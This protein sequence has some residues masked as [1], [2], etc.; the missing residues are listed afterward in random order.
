M[1][2]TKS[3]ARVTP[4]PINVFYVWY[5]ELC[6]RMNCTPAPAVKPA[7]PK[8][9]TILEFVADRLRVEEWNPIVNALRHD[10]SLHVISIRGRI[11]NCQFLVDI[12]TEEKA[13]HMKRRFGSL[14]TAYVL[15]QL[16]KSL[17]C[18]LR[19]TQ[20]LTCLE[21]DGLPM[22]SQYIEPLLQAL[23]KNKTLKSLSF[24]NS[25]I[26]DDG[27]Q[28]VC[29]H[30][31]FTP[32]VEIMNLSGCGLTYTSGE[33]IA[34]LIK[35]QQINRYCESW[36]NSLRYENP[37]A[38][39]MRGIKRI[40]LNCN[41][42]FCDEGFEFILDELEDDLWI[43]AL[44]LQK[45]GLTENVARKIVDVV[46]Y[47]K[48]LEIL[49]IRNN[50]LLSIET[51]DKVLQILRTK[52]Q[53]GY[54]P[55]YQWCNTTTTLVWNS[56]RDNESKFSLTP[57]NLHKSKSAPIKNIFPKSSYT[58]DKTVR[59]SRTVDNM[60]RRNGIKNDTDQKLIELNTK[61]LSEIQKRREMEKR[62]EELKHK[63]EE[64]KSTVKLQG[65]AN[66]VNKN[67]KTFVSSVKINH[68]NHT[69]G[70]YPQK[71]NLQNINLEKSKDNAENG[72][73]N[74]KKTKTVKG[75]K[76]GHT[77]GFS[78]KIINSACKIFES[79]LMKESPVKYERDNDLLNNF[80][81]ETKAY[82]KSEEGQPVDSSGS[83]ISL[84]EYMEEI[85]AVNQNHLFKGHNHKCNSKYTRKEYQKR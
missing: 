7:K 58:V 8:C 13:R 73:V 62:N 55:E 1:D 6:R 14:W 59:K 11:N 40:S 44:D 85:K 70:D 46:E 21:L 48:S 61:L 17:S 65:Q 12:D 79:L 63:L 77:N 22:F 75:V 29:A 53:A 78:S 37:Q 60:Q 38:G 28:L 16:L 19:N 20:V 83:Q 27:C 69:H 81:N 54:Q 15:Q 66:G 51:V 34:K 50:D 24:A 9:Q 76:N 68:K 49:D 10:T 41:P 33:Y 42:E 84:L 74:F 31:K 32:N 57:G 82:I 56:V 36:H 35:Y 39:V 80:A 52:Q 5:T 72:K 43:K 47:S 30:L 67:L 26:N 25:P 18:S 23:K 64:I 2:T 4:K 3:T 71:S 45:C